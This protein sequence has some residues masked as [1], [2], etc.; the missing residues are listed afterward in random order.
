MTQIHGTVATE[1][2]K[3]RQRFTFEFYRAGDGKRM[4]C[5]GAVGFQKEFANPVLGDKILI[6]GDIYGD[7]VYASTVEILP[8]STTFETQSNLIESKETSPALPASSSR[9]T[10]NIGSTDIVFPRN[11]S[12][13]P[14]DIERDVVGG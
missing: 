10:I 2:K 7:E 6:S 8:W 11:V 9:E 5:V 4:V 12:E 1:R 3:D 14:D 13:A